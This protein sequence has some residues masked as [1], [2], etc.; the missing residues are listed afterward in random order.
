VDVSI[1]RILP[2]IE[3]LNGALIVTADHGNADEMYQVD[4]KGK[5]SLDKA[6]KPIVKTSHTLN[7]VPFLVYAPGY[8][9]AID[10]TVKKPGLSNIAASVLHLLGYQAPESYQHSIVRGA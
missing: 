10:D 7:E 2:I 1:G 8:K 4:K 9:L 5:I 6:G 3:K